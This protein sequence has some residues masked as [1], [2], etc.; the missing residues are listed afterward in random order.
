MK[1][2]D[3]WTPEDYATVLRSSI[4]QGLVSL[5]TNVDIPTP[6]L[7]ALDTLDISK[8]FKLYISII[9]YSPK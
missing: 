2:L 9:H 5:L 7:E 8:N 1:H 3:A 6:S 4:S